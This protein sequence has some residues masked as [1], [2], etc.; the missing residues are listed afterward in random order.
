[1]KD[2]NRLKYSEDTDGTEGE[3]IKDMGDINPD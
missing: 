3:F 1:M 2:L